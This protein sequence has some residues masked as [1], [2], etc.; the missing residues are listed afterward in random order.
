MSNLLA[1]LQ[2]AGNSHDVSKDLTLCLLS[3]NIFG[4]ITKYK[5]EKR[6]PEMA[7][8][9]ASQEAELKIQV[10]TAQ[11]RHNLPQTRGR[12]KGTKTD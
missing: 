3:L 2:L 10:A 1:H 8:L 5:I 7:R 9:P 12:S 6:K 4:K 11:R